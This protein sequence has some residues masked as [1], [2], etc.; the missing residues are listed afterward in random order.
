MRI[1][2]WRRRFEDKLEIPPAA[3][4]LITAMARHRPDLPITVRSRRDLAAHGT[5][6]YELSLRGWKKTEVFSPYP[7]HVSFANVLLP[8]PRAVVVQEMALVHPAGRISISLESVVGTPVV[9]AGH[10][11]SEDPD[12]AAQHLIWHYNA[13]LPHPVDAGTLEAAEA[14]LL[15]AA[16]PFVST[17][18]EGLSQEGRDVFRMLQ[19]AL[20]GG[21]PEHGRRQVPP[22]DADGEILADTDQTRRL[23]TA[24][25]HYRGLL[26]ARTS[27]A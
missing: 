6:R 9:Y 8:N 7:V 27:L 24:L 14:E 11:A 10:A 19:C 20:S 21:Y 18:A 26:A 17:G 16:Y 15:K 1:S 22:L 4:A 13:A 5:V 12:E 25:T 2:T 23:R 3:A